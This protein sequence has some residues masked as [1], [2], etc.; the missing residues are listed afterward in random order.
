MKP[1]TETPCGWRPSTRCMF[2]LMAALASTICYIAFIITTYDQSI[3]DAVIDVPLNTQ[4]TDK[5]RTENRLSFIDSDP[6]FLYRDKSIK[7]WLLEKPRDVIDNKRREDRY[8]IIDHRRP[9]SAPTIGYN[10]S[11]EIKRENKYTISPQNPTWEYTQES[12]RKSEKITTNNQAISMGKLKDE[13]V[14]SS[15]SKNTFDL[16]LGQG[17]FTLEF[18]AN[19]DFGS[20][21]YKAYW[22][23]SQGPFM[24]RLSSY[25]KAI[26]ILRQELIKKRGDVPLRPL[27]ESIQSI[28]CNR[29]DFHKELEN[30]P[31]VKT[32]AWAW[33]VTTIGGKLKWDSRKDQDNL[34][35]Q[36]YYPW[37][38]SD[39][40][41]NWIRT[42]GFTK[43]RWDAV[44]NKECRTLTNITG[45][46]HS[47]GLETVYLHGKPINKQHYWPNHGFKYP[48][49]FYST[50][51]PQ[52]IYLHIVEDAVITSLGDVISG[53]LKL[54]PYSC[55][56]DLGTSP[57]PDYQNSP[58]HDEIFIMGQYWGG[59]FFH[60][61]LE[62][63]PRIAPYVS[64][65]QANP[66]ILIHAQS[67][68]GHTAKL[69][70]VLTLNSTRLIQGTVRA[71]RVYLPQATPCGFAQIQST[72]LLASLYGNYLLPTIQTHQ[73]RSI[74]LIRRSGSRR[75][76]QQT[77]IQSELGA[78]AKEFNLDFE[79]FIDNPSPSMEQTMVMF[80]RAVL[81]VGPH[82]AGL[83][84]VIYCEPGTLIIEGVCN[85]PHVNMCYQWAAHILGHRYHGIASRGGCET[86]VDVDYHLVIDAARAML[87]QKADS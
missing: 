45:V 4:E 6:H 64:F 63:M 8:T 76:T 34:L 29:D 18:T 22:V 71:R 59:S 21:A 19:F 30:Y 55:S 27:S 81:V 75:F 44:Y 43:A 79:I 12:V 26:H 46:M 56:Q 60:L 20:G 1:N 86:W 69:L 5:E 66:L 62:N 61:M 39:N 49:Y 77:K 78:V 7:D 73:R 24:A 85:P 74:L 68:E 35:I 52:V 25:N 3:D 37:T 33:N 31:L 38:G 28:W 16:D 58:I 23:R 13:L 40:L 32:V 84:N 50:P 53:N 57:P 72:Q 10:I 65:L 41:C 15:A 47:E 48:E 14:V 67:R 36:K 17:N 83:S 70:E 54:I 51:P 11:S 87:Q 80:R 9:I 2:F 42:P 82:G